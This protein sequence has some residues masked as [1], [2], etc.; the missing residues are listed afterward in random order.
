MNRRHLRMALRIGIALLALLVVAVALISLLPSLFMQ[1]LV[2]NV[3]NYAT[4]EVFYATDRKPTGS[5]EAN[6][7]YGFQRGDLQLG[8]CRV[9][10]PRDHRMGELESPS[11]WRLEFRENP[12]KH[13][14]LLNVEPMTPGLFW[15]ELSDQV[16]LSEGQSAFVFVHG[17]NTTFR[18]AARRTA[19]IAYDLGFDGAPVMYSWPSKGK[20]SIDGYNHDQTNIDWSVPHLKAFLEDLR[21]KS[22]AK[23]IHL[24]SHSMGSRYLTSALTSI[25]EN[26][27]DPDLPAFNEVVLTAPDID[28]ATF[29]DVIAPAIREV[30]ERIT[31]YA[32]SEDVALQLSKKFHGDYPRAGDSG[33]GIVAVRGI[34]SIDVS[35][36]DS[37][38]VGHGYYAENRT[39][40]TDLFLLIRHGLD[41]AERNLKPVHTADADYWVFR[42]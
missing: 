13:V 22:G 6:E 18:N 19:Q 9:S 23:T 8:I 21:T 32:S 5:Q 24:I 28:A 7:A 20:A 1:G 38:L 26:L 15:N 40:I 41:P 37:S 31:L 17:F 11:V 2:P 34:D 14:V 3:N 4:V 42:P 10:V 29:R 16:I 39:V 36:V 30:A 12:E 27:E 25:A 33:P 35:S